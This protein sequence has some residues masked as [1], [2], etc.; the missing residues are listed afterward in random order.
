MNSSPSKD[1]STPPK[2]HPPAV[3]DR[4]QLDVPRNPWNRLKC[5]RDLRLR[6]L[7]LRTRMDAENSVLRL[8][9]YLESFLEL[10][11]SEYGARI[12]FVS[13]RWTCEQLR[14]DPVFRALQVVV[15]STG[16][17][18]VDTESPSQNRL[19]K[20]GIPLEAASGMVDL[21][22]IGDLDGNVVLI[23]T[24]QDCRNGHEGCSCTPKCTKIPLRSKK[25]KCEFVS[26]CLS[27][28][29]NHASWEHR[30]GLEIHG[31]FEFPQS[32]LD[33]IN[34][35]EIFVIQTDIAC[36]SGNFGDK[37]RIDGLL[38][39]NMTSWV[40]NM[41][42]FAA[43]FD[44]T[45][46]IC[47]VCSL[48]LESSTECRLHIIQSHGVQKLCENRRCGNGSL[49]EMFGVDDPRKD[50]ERLTGYPVYNAPREKPFHEWHAALV[51][52]DIGDILIVAI[53]LW[54]IA[55]DI[56][57]CQEVPEEASC[58]EFLR[59]FLH[60][61]KEEP[62]LTVPSAGSKAWPFPKFRVQN[63][64]GCSLKN[65]CE[66]VPYLPGGP[67][68]RDLPFPIRNTLQHAQE[69]FDD[70]YYAR[71]RKENILEKY[72]IQGYNPLNI[73]KNTR[74]HQP[75]VWPPSREVIIIEE[76]CEFQSPSSSRNKNT[77]RSHLASRKRRSSSNELEYSVPKRR[78]F[79]RG[80]TVENVATPEFYGVCHRCGD[81]HHVVR[82]CPLTLGPGLCA[83]PICNTNETHQIKVCNTLHHICAVCKRRGHYSNHHTRYTLPELK[84]FFDYFSPFGFYT[85][86]PILSIDKHFWYKVKASEYSFGFFCANRD[87][88]YGQLE[89]IV[90]WTPR[91]FCDRKELNEE[92]RR[93]RGIM[94]KRIREK[95]TEESMSEDLRIKLNRRIRL[96]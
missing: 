68:L 93:Q 63:V 42:A 55:V 15:E 51:K 54:Q 36:H 67:K 33:W 53:M 59:N 35:K 91:Q 90:Q 65:P 30:D 76:G 17:L 18:I 8:K 21:F 85:C 88:L 27:N 83:Y 71:F 94:K 10:D 74:R 25:G 60:L 58:L 45:P 66:P 24:I 52:Y 95:K 4:E 22:Q 6:L 70:R 39:T 16:I 57:K 13:R 56:M 38:G 92:D 61:I 5:Q 77:T 89:G 31:F 48:S 73:A 34:D 78:V 14:N 62:S 82:D 44:A 20:L 11:R 49:F 40:E 12:S 84:N 96:V 7:P 87:S 64:P 47:P 69:Y 50:L 41:N 26:S 72:R 28:R 46:T 37:E 29:G 75:C 79:S 2:R 9:S 1:T 43:F 80:L 3:Q 32:I 81:E 86:L 23:Q 19:K